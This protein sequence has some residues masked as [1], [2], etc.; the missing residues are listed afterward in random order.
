MDRLNNAARGLANAARDFLPDDE[1]DM[2]MPRKNPNRDTMH[3]DRM[4]YNTNASNYEKVTET[5]ENMAKAS[6]VNKANADLGRGDFDN[7]LPLMRLDGNEQQGLG[8]LKPSSLTMTDRERLSSVETFLANDQSHNYLTSRNG[9]VQEI[10]ERF[11]GEHFAKKEKKAKKT[12]KIVYKEKDGIIVPVEVK[13]PR[14]RMTGTDLRLQ[15]NGH[16]GPDDERFLAD[17]GRR[18]H[19]GSLIFETRDERKYRGK[20]RMGVID[21]INKLPTTFEIDSFL[22]DAYVDNGYDAPTERF[23]ATYDRVSSRANR[24]NGPAKFSQRGEAFLSIDDNADKFLS[25]DRD[26]FSH[27]RSAGQSSY[28]DSDASENDM[29]GVQDRFYNI[30]SDRGQYRGPARFSVSG[31][32]FGGY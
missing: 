31:E 29:Y 16:T 17:N 24:I 11:S 20:D 21:T 7:Q 3:A 15:I 19:I 30:S 13:L 1:Y 23:N 28:A 4:V 32:A 8:S 22:A 12:T 2:Q 9:S 14:E 27:A 26:Q 6:R 18:E 10:D 25:Y 5:M